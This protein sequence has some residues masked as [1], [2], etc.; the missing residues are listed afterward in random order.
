MTIYLSN[1]VCP[2]ENA[3]RMYD[4]SLLSNPDP[5]STE[6]GT[7][8]WKETNSFPPQT[9]TIYRFATLFLFPYGIWNGYKRSPLLGLV[10]VCAASLL[11]SFQQRLEENRKSFFKLLEDEQKT[12][13]S[14]YA[15]IGR[16]FLAASTQMQSDLTVLWNDGS[17][18]LTPNGEIDDKQKSQFNEMRKKYMGDKNFSYN[19][20]TVSYADLSKYAT[21][22]AKILPKSPA[23]KWVTDLQKVCSIWGQEVPQFVKL[24]YALNAKGRSFSYFENGTPTSATYTLKSEPTA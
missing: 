9:Q 16:L 7:K 15:E 21:S 22:I 5:L 10:I 11:W 24:E 14:I 18:T 2:I 20:E 13:G 12:E 3:K 4:Y 17:V 8:L 1:D 19:N 6:K 23:P